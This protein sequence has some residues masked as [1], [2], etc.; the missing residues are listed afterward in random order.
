MTQDAKNCKK[1]EI[2]PYLQT[3]VLVCP[4]FMDVGWRP[5][6]PSL[7]PRPLLL[8]AQKAEWALTYLH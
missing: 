8:M 5:K 2:L 4:I 3:N 7:R 6:T 1:P